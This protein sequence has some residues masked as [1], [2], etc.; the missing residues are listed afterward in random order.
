MGTCAEVGLAHQVEGFHHH[1][2]SRANGAAL[3][4]AI[5]GFCPVHQAGAGR[6]PFMNEIQRYLAEEIAL[7]ANDGIITRREALR[8]LRVMGLSIASATTL[9]GA[10][11]ADDEAAVPATEPV[12]PVDEMP[13][14]AG[15][16]GSSVI[17]TPPG[18][19]NGDSPAPSD[20]AQGGSGGE[21][22]PSPG[23]PE[24]PGQ[25]APEQPAPAAGTPLA[26]EEITFAGPR[27]PLF[28]AFAAPASPLGA[29]LVIHENRGL[30]D[31]IRSVAGRLAGAGYAALA[32]DLL[33]QEGGT[34]S[35]GDPANATAA[36]GRV[37]PE[38]FVADMIGGL[39]ELARRAPG[40]KLGAIGFCFGGGMM[41]QLVQAADARLAVAVPFYGPLPQGASFTGAST[42]V[43]AFY[44]ELDT[45]V[46]STR[47]AA[48]QAL[49]AA[50][51]PHEA[52]TFPGADHAFFND[53]G[54]R[55]NAPAAAEAWTRLLAWFAQYLGA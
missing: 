36:L 4:A 26:T 38:R 48:V 6:L 12:L 5:V 10:C 33:S 53:T 19:G 51:L 54:A 7:D 8:R 1:E 46:T 11:S 27:G 13:T 20:L 21:P 35:L 25:P 37:A 3:P 47:D 34:A 41:W 15:A 9:L 32:L 24:A 39:D 17:A 49:E 16:G 18:A 43:L 44:G 45:R 14:P 42:A 40:A 31:H 23:T 2:T 29:V 30:N 52:V 22:L 50:G 28:G 55:Y